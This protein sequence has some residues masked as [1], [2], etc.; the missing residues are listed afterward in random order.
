MNLFLNTFIITIH[1]LNCNIS[2][3]TSFYTSNW[4]KML[5]SLMMNE[6]ISKK[7]ARCILNLFN[8]KE[9]KYVYQTNAFLT[10]FFIWVMYLY[11]NILNNKICKIQVLY[12]CICSY[13]RICKF[14]IYLQI[15]SINAILK[16]IYDISKKGSVYTSKCLKLDKSNMMNAYIF[17]R[18]SWKNYNF[19]IYIIHRLFQS[20]PTFITFFF[21]LI[22]T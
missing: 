22:I 1:D 7:D 3:E 17:K 19:N 5:I 13:I 11:Q 12:S 9:H 4:I 14:L 6:C 8:Q 2:I 21:I 15:C 18:T 16:Q 20:F 10:F